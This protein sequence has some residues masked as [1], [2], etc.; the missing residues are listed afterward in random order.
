[1][2]SGDLSSTEKEKSYSDFKQSSRDVHPEGF[3]AVFRYRDTALT[4]LLVQRS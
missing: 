4:C 2:T 1:M 3:S